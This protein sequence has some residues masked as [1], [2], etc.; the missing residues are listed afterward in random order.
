M[1]KPVMTAARNTTAA[2]TDS[3]GASDGIPALGGPG[4][5]GR[6]DAGECGCGASARPRVGVFSVAAISADVPAVVWRMVIGLA[7]RMSSAWRAGT[8]AGLR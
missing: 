6:A 4:G 8:V 2:C 3:S 5:P 1:T 7:S